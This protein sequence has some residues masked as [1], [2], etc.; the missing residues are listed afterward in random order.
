ERYGIGDCKI[1]EKFL[2]MI[3]EHNL[4]DN[5]NNLH[6]LEAL[7]ISLRTQSHSYVENF[8]KLD[9]NEHLKNLLSECSRRSGLEQHATAILLC[10]RALLNSTIGRLAVLSSDATLC[11]IASSTCLQSAKCKI[12]P[13]FFFDKI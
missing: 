13:F 5:D 2:E 1:A 7:F 12:L 11:V 9:G 10:F 6:I 3:Q 8:V 4:L